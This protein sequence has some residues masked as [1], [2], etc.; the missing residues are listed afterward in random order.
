MAA[1]T[2][3]VGNAGALPSGSGYGNVE[4]DAT[5]DLN[6]CDAAVNGLT[7]TGTVTTSVP[8][9]VTFTVCENDQTS[10]FAGAIQDGA[11]TVAVVKAGSGTLVYADAETYTGG[12]Q[13]DAGAG[14]VTVDGPGSMVCY[15]TGV[16]SPSDPD[17]SDG[18]NWL[19]GEAPEPNDAIV[20]G[21]SQF[22][23]NNKA[24]TDNLGSGPFQSITFEA[25][26]FSIDIHINNSIP[27]PALA[28]SATVTVDAGAE[29]GNLRRSAGPC[30]GS[31]LRRSR[32]ADR[33]LDNGR[34]FGPGGRDDHRQP[35]K[36]R[37]WHADAHHDLP[38][39]IQREYLY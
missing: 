27:P 9:L 31:G 8:G 5:L 38:L 37:G 15:W 33:R 25:D 7:G 2:L 10:T 12:T 32:L 11:G 1:G 14:P 24:T 29:R 36:D 30:R 35:G 28:I 26:G 23:T 6:G 20:F 4:V 18:S 19:S 34:L 16:S 21:A 13:R 22:P 39:C 17:W 3:Q